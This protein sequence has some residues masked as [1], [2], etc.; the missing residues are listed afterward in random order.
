MSSFLPFWRVHITI[1]LKW[2][3]CKVADRISMRSQM[4]YKTAC[5]TFWWLVRRTESVRLMLLTDC[6]FYIPSFFFFF[7]SHNWEISHY[8]CLALQSLTTIFWKILLLFF[9]HPYLHIINYKWLYFRFMIFLV[10]CLQVCRHVAR[11]GEG[12]KERDL[13]KG[14]L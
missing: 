10:I 2:V 4:W 12:C 9:H 14:W 1:P 11:L 8:Q 6:F 7:F 3:G 5:N 13:C